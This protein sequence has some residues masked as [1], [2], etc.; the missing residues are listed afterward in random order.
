MVFFTADHHFNHPKVI[1]FCQRPFASIEEMTERLIASWNEVIGRGDTVYHLGDFC[2]TWG[3]RDDALVDSLLSRLNG[4]KH[5]IYGNHD[6]DVVKESPRWGW[7]GDYK[8][9]TVDKQKIVLFHYPI[10]SWRSNHHGSWH[11]H[12]HS[13]GSLTDVGGYSMDVGVDCTEYRPI[14]FEEV[15]LYMAGREPLYVD[16]HEPGI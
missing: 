13:H 14:S 16:H 1:E 9:I 4:N 7:A 15:R 8:Y 12:G 3:K 6:R 10:R 11:L 2:L 5:L